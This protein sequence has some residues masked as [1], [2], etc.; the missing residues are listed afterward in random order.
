MDGGRS[1]ESGTA[2]DAGQAGE[3]DGFAGVLLKEGVLERS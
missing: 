2:A 1:G 3:D